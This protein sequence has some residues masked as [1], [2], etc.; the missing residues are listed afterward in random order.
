MP[1]EL[2]V[3]RP[4]VVNGSIY[5]P[6]LKATELTGNVDRL[7]AVGPR[8]VDTRVDLGHVK[9]F[10]KKS[11]WVAGWAEVNAL[12]ASLGDQRRQLLQPPLLEQRATALVL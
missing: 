8:S 1:A 5:G 7:V 3:A 11:G 6:V 2:E 9:G 4:A 12:Q 10:A